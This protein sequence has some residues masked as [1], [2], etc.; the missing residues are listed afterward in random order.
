MLLGALFESRK[1][2][3]SIQVTLCRLSENE[4]FT[5]IRGLDVLDEYILLIS[6]SWWDLGSERHTNALPA[7][8]QQYLAVCL[9]C[10]FKR[11]MSCQWHVGRLPWESFMQH[12][13]KRVDYRSQFHVHHVDL[14]VAP[15]Q[16]KR[17]TVESRSTHGTIQCCNTRELSHSRGKVPDQAHDTIRCHAGCLS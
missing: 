7:T 1:V 3:L 13:S 9:V 15:I 11:W 5:K 8:F 14:I 6:W 17:R 4:S 10:L 16:N 2:A 12:S